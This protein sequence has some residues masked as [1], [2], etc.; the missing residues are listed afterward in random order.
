MTYKDKLR[1]VKRRLKQILKRGDKA[2]QPKAIQTDSDEDLEAA[3]ADVLQA[4]NGIPGLDPVSASSFAR[5]MNH[6]ILTLALKTELDRQGIYYDYETLSNLL[7]VIGPINEDEDSI[8]IN[9]DE[10]F[11]ARSDTLNG[12]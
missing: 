11:Q 8:S 2:S 10:V 6:H 7:S 4:S 5:D 1:N 9:V 12:Q 3:I